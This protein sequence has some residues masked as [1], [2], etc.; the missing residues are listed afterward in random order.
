MLDDPI[1]EPR[2]A[3]ALAL[4]R[5]RASQEPKAIEALIQLA[6]NDSHEWVRARALL[7]IGLIGGDAGEAFF[8]Q[9]E[10]PTPYLR[11]SV[12]ISMGLL[13]DHTL[14]VSDGL[15][16][17]LSRRVP[18]ASNAA[19][20]AL[21]QHPDNTHAEAARQLF[22]STNS[23]WLTSAAILSLRKASDRLS[24]RIL[25]H[26]LLN[27]PSLR[28]VPAWNLLTQ[29]ARDKPL[30]REAT[31]LDGVDPKKLRTKNRGI[32]PLRQW[33]NQHKRVFDLEPTPIAVG[34]QPKKYKRMERVTGIEAIYKT[35]LRASA[36]IAISGAQ[37]SDL[38]VEA[39]TRLVREQDSKYNTL[40]KCFAL[41]SLARIGSPKSLEVLLSVASDTNGR[42]IKRQKDLESPLR[43]FAMIALG[44]YTRSQTTEQGPYD[45]PGYQIALEMLQQRLIDKREK[46]E[47]RTAAAVA[48]G[49]SGRTEN[50]KLL[51]GGYENFNDTS[52]LLGGY[53]L[54]GRALLGDRNVIIPARAALDRKPHHDKTTDLLARRAAVLSLGVA[55]TSEA[56]PH[57]IWAW[58][59]S[60]YVNREVIVALSLCDAS[61]VAVHLL[62]RLSG[63]ANQYERAFMAEAV[64]RLLN[65]DKLPP[66]SVFLIGS[67]FT[68]KN[69][70]LEPYRVLE[71]QFLYD[72]L[73]PEFQEV[74][75]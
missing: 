35:R 34:A 72:Y 48:L 10:P 13:Q 47:V 46:L 53:V 55:G 21:S 69:G 18:S 65:R 2:A 60:F 24:D 4:G 57:L 16:R 62:P 68:M 1:A 54:L 52:P 70:L 44:L 25:A 37:N 49:L 50:L 36:A 20:W 64:G 17:E 9:Y 22:Q 51:I 29:V 6:E 30:I 67:N 7:A 56:I 73:I 61:G 5:M 74:W 75:Y 15:N 40:P 38:A 32:P 23:P 63:D 33:F 45:R 28:Q 71:N 31:V 19:W 11:A 27:E 14:R 43:G 59:Q 66:L 3:A 58:D 41:I 12:L 8:L 26:V 42:R 39:L